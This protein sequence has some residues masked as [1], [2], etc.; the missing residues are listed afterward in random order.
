MKNL[1][2]LKEGESY[3][4]TN[5][6]WNDKIE[7]DGYGTVYGIDFLLQKKIGRITGWIGYTWMKNYRIFENI[8][9]GKEY[10]Y[11]YDRRHDFSIVINHKL[12]ENIDLSLTWVYGTGQ[13]LTLPI[14]KYYLPMIFPGSSNL[15]DFYMEKIYIYTEKNAFRAKAYHR[16]DI[17][18]NFRKSKKW[19]ERIWNISIYNLYNRKNPYSYY[20]AGA[21]NHNNSS[22]KISLFQQSLFPF[23]PSVSYSIKF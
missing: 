5:K 17:G 16:L 21:S 13:A 6:T 2:T 20:F 11:K 15:E 14:A 19:G 7:T 18:I 3:F 23:I 22:G 8:N 12:K 1:T 10:P 4:G 9:N